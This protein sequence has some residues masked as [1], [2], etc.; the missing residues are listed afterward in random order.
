MAQKARFPM[1]ILRVTQGY[2]YSVDGVSAY[3]YSHARSY[4]LDLGG[5]DGGQDWLYAPCDIRC[6]RI[7]GNYNAM[8]FESTSPVLCADGV[9]R[10]I[11]I[12]CIHMNNSDKNALGMYVGKVIPQGQRFYREGTAGNATGNH[13]HLEVGAGPFT[14]TGWHVEYSGGKAYWPINN[15]L[16]PHKVFFLGPDVKQVNPIYTWTIDKGEPPIITPDIGFTAVSNKLLNVYASNCEYFNTTSVNDPVGKLPQGGSYPCTAVSTAKK[17][18]YDWAKFTMNGKTYYTALVQDGRCKVEEVTSP[19]AFSKGQRVFVSGTLFAS[20][21][22][23]NG[24]YKKGN[25]YWIY[26]GVESNGR[27]RVTNSAS[28]VGKTPTSRYVSGYVAKSAMRKA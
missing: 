21:T 25:Y 22:A 17:D 3:T 14:G 28:Y 15:R 2:G 4:A 10:T 16:M 18:G 13:V 12:E 20:S 24:T 8:W 27:Y 19:S 1:E 11:V 26:D 7:Y 6:R 23:K 5:K 9:T